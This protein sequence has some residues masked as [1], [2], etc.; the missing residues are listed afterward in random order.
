M[1]NIRFRVYNNYVEIILLFF[2]PDTVLIRIRNKGRKQ[3]GH[4]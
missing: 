4:E 1:L 2:S 3:S